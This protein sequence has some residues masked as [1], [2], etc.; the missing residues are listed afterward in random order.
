[1]IQVDNVLKCH[2]VKDIEIIKTKDTVLTT[3]DKR[4]IIDFEAGIWCTALGHNNDKI[5]Q[6]I[7]N[8]AN[9]MIHLNTRY[10]TKEASE[11]A[12]KLLKLTGLNDGKA[13]FLSSGSEAVELAISIVSLLKK[14]KKFITF[15]Q[16]YL[17]AYNHRSKNW[18]KI[19]FEKYNNCKISEV[20]IDRDLSK[21]DF[22]KIS[23][24]ILEPGSSSGRFIFPPKI[25]VEYLYKKIKEH[26]GYLIVNEVTTGFG[27][28]GKLFGYQHYD[29]KPDVVAMGKALGNGYPISGVVMSNVIATALESLEFKYAQSH[30]NDPLGCAV[31]NKVIEIFTK[32]NMVE[33]ANSKGEIILKEL[34]Q[35]KSSLIKEVRGRGLMCA[36][37]LN[38]NNLTEV[39][40]DKM[41]SKG[42]AIGTTP[43]AN[44]LRFSPSITIKIEDIKKMATTLEMI[45]ND[46]K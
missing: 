37:E 34:K 9:N 31:A 32:E 15:S 36:I 22:S 41:F 21:I 24:F 40:F 11:L 18:E 27:K 39:I 44:V 45:L 1:V 35:I 20:N 3:Y 2:P 30:Q 28:T 10:I 23:G 13:V 42:F 19:D 38:K 17:S 8:Q 29:V 5:N 6:V 14:N 4:E 46:L 7:I 26:N 12:S 33:K 25:L 43:K 16:S